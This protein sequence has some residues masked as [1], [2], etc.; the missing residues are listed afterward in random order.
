MATAAG[1][2]RILLA[3]KPLSQTSPFLKVF[4]GGIG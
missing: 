1:T 3:A 2:M 4:I